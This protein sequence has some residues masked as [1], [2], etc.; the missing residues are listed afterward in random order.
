MGGKSSQSNSTD[1]A[2]GIIN[3][4]VAQQEEAD[5]QSRIRQGMTR[6]NG[7][8]AGFDDKYYNNYATAANEY[9]MPQL[10]DQYKDAKSELAYRLARAGTLNSSIAA[11]NTADLAKQNSINRATVLAQ[12]DQAAAN[13]KSRVNAEKQ[14]IMQQLYSSSDP[15]MAANSALTASKGIGQ[16]QP[17]MSPLGQMFN[18]AT[19]GAANFM[20]GYNTSKAYQNAFNS[21]SPNGGN[22]STN[23]SSWIG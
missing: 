2:M 22:A 10:E 23:R 12:G 18:V 16:D 13:L 9:S 3:A 15:D 6:I 4:F 7:A 17:S 20:N 19:I 5:R 21:G 11:T 8:F 1:Q 14:A